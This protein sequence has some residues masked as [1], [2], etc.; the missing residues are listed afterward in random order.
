[1]QLEP[2]IRV[3]GVEYAHFILDN[4][5]DLYLTAHGLPH[6][7]HLMPDRYYTDRAWFRANHERLG[8]TSASYRIRTKPIEG[9]SRDIVL[10]WNRMGQDIP[11]ATRA[12]DAATA[13]FNSPFEEFALTLELR[14]AHGDRSDRVR[15][16]KPLAIYVP[17][18]PI[19]WDRSSRD[20]QK[21][22]VKQRT[23]EDIELHG[24]RSYA[25]IY[26]WIKGIDA[27]QACREGRISKDEAA[28][29]VRAVDSR[30]RDQ[31]F[32]VRDNKP[33][34]IIVRP[35]GDRLKRDRQD[36]P[37]W[38]Y[39]DFELLQRT[40]EREQEVRAAKRKLY[41]IKQAKRFQA[42]AAPPAHLHR[43]RV[44]DVDY[45]YGR[46]RSTNGALWVVGRDPDL[47]DYFLPEKWR[48]TPRTKMAT[49]QQV[50][51]TTTKDNIR[52]MWR[53]SRAGERPDMDPFH[54][55]E[56]RILEHGFNS[57]FEEI[58][59]AMRLSAGGVG[60]VYPR[61][62]YMTG[63]GA[64]VS[65]RISDER[66]YGTHASL[67]TPD[68]KA[69]LRKGHD[70]IIIWGYWNGPDELLA[71]KDEPP[72]TSISA[73]Q[74]LRDGLVDEPLYLRLMA[75]TRERLAELGIEDLNLRGTHLILSLKASGDLERDAE[76]LP[77]VLVCNFEL[78]RSR[79]PLH[80]MLAEPRR[81]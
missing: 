19:D 59:L 48:K 67:Q 79:T 28:R 68:G 11:G 49:D 64:T 53:V 36:T 43:V 70:Y 9:R 66:R 51:E 65:S 60:A 26:E 75:R 41:L 1:M 13:E 30:M 5:D 57:P 33:H 54:P 63:D 39:I 69:V 55:D 58:M 74:A 45:I 61:A 14:E 72:Y 34:H 25:V 2:R 32:V 73:L 3:M 18:K 27:A 76:G 44:F 56:K 47:F 40:P 12:D 16:H 50:F 35:Q 81:E 7:A 46:I 8:G 23:H 24:N 38:A 20:R 42:D 62:I 52:L 31:G 4:G 78:L 15:T 17:A 80:P 77:Q 6:A 37:I 29:L 71:V 22:E 10:K 21:F